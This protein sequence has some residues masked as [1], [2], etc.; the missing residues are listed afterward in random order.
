MV[1]TR[2]EASEEAAREPGP[3]RAWMVA[4]GPP[5]RRFLRRRVSDAEA[6]EM[7]QE[8][9]LAIHARRRIDPIENPQGYLFRAARHLLSRRHATF[10]QH[11]EEDGLHAGI[12]LSTPEQQL[13]DKDELRRTMLAIEALPPR[14]RQAFVLHRFEEMTYAAIATEMRI[15]LSAVRQLISRAIAQIV[16][17]VGR[18]R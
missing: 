15:S 17:E 9:F 3:L 10:D 2:Y 1:E 13:L 5:L 8:V 7:V 6:E 11:F 4:Y 16:Q 18:S 12:D 14:A